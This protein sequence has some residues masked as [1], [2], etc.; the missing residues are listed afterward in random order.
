LNRPGSEP[1]SSLAVA[2]FQNEFAM[3]IDA[4]VLNQIRKID[5]ERHAKDWNW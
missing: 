5:W 3:P 4:E 2:W 1:Y